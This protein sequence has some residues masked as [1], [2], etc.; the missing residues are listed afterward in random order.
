MIRLFEFM[1]VLTFLAGGCSKHSSPNV[2]TPLPGSFKLISATLNGTPLGSTATG[3]NLSPVF[4]FSFNS[5]VDHTSVTNSVSLKDN[6]GASVAYSVT[7]ANSDSVV[8]I[9]PGSALK[10]LSKYSFDLSST[11]VSQDKIQLQTATHCQFLTAIDSTDKFPR[12]S[13]SALLD[14][15]QKQTLTYFWDFGHPVSGLARERTSSGD[16]VTT[17]GSGFGIM[18]M[19]AGIQRNF[20]TRA[21]GLTRVIKF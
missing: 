18:G 17:G 7:Y 1:M 3:V 6:S 16:V 8:V 10:P 4:R 11:V 12:I 20:I 14:L 15:V 5:P 2:V 9:Q 21:Q 13:D 19:L